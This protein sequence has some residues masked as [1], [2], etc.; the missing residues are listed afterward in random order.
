V[1]SQTTARIT[2]IAT[3]FTVNLGEPMHEWITVVLTCRAGE[4]PHQ[5]E[6]DTWAIRKGGLCLNRDERWAFEPQ[7]SSRD[8]EWLASHRWEHTEAIVVAMRIAEREAN[9]RRDAR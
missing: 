2:P 6:R 9:W 7:P 8:D 3:T 1:P 5:P 4:G